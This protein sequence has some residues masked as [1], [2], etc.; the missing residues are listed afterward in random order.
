MKTNVKLLWSDVKTAGCCEA[1][2]AGCEAVIA[3]QEDK[4]ET[5]QEDKCEV[6]IAG[7]EDKHN[8]PKFNE[9]VVTGCDDDVNS[10]KDQKN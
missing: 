9:T 8:D 1:V 10:M 2:V 3:G 6:G 4:C 7:C 5:R